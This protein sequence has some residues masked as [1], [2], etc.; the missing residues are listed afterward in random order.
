MASYSL[1][2]RQLRVLLVDRAVFPRWKVCGC[3]LNPQT[4]R[5]LE[6]AGL[7]DLASLSRAAPISGMRLGAGGS[8]AGINL[9]GW[10]VL[11]R[12]RLDASLVEAAVAAGACFLPGTQAVLGAELPDR[13][14]AILRRPGEEVVIGARLIIAADGLASRLLLN[15][16]GCQ[17]RFAANSRIGVG[18]VTS[19][20][21]EHYERETIHM[22]YGR[23]SYMG[24]VR[25]ENGLLNV[26]AALDIEFLKKSQSPG[27]AIAQLLQETEWPAIAGL[28]ELDWQGT[29]PLTRTAVRPASGR[30]FAIGDA[31]GYVEPF[32][33]EGIGWALA[34]GASVVSLSVRAV[35]NW[36][37][38]LTEEW[39]AL[40][41]RTRIRSR[42]ACRAVTWV[43]KRPALTRAL[44]SL[45]GRAP[46]LANPI[47]NRIGTSKSV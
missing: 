21:P 45:V 13:R 7:G 34:S 3:C 17:M 40:S 2:Q 38:R 25:L 37:P 19:A 42:Q 28:A 36:Q 27:R 9:S 11:S 30:V 47:V 14:T 5:N 39:T 32:T 44:I 29:P 23:G 10:R 15:E 35:R 24:L 18:A 46:W 22:A 4:L 26:A 31:S 16:P 33:G 20:A 12:E 43:S 41:N 8:R 6:K 1:A